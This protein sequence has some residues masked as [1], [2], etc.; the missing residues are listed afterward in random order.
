MIPRRNNG[1]TPQSDPAFRA[2]LRG[3]GFG[4]DKTSETP[5][6]EVDTF[7]RPTCC[8]VLERSSQYFCLRG[9]S[10]MPDPLFYAN[11]Q[12]NQSSSCIGKIVN[13]QPIRT[14]R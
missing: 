5:L 6:R 12:Y 11:G 2:R 14:I 4:S 3:C 7:E 8:R 10:D 13:I 1:A 9:A